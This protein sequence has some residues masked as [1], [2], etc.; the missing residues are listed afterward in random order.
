MIRMFLEKEEV[1]PHNT[2]RLFE[3]K[4]NHHIIEVWSAAESNTGNPVYCSLSDRDV[5]SALQSLMK[6]KNFTKITEGKSP[7]EIK[8]LVELVLCHHFRESTR[9]YGFGH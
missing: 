4:E 1:M 3:K 7:E 6:D 5:N 9:Y 8:S 2:K